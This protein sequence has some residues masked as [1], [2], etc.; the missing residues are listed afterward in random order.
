LQ[1]SDSPVDYCTI[2]G[3]GMKEPPATPNVFF[4]FT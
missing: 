2:T 4:A 3:K 1:T